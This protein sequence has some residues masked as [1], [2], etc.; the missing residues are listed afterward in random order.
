MRQKPNLFYVNIHNKAY[1]DGA[2]RGQL[3]IP[4]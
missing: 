4:A 1:P 2:I 3:R